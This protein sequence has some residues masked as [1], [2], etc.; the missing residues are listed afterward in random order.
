MA[1]YV[2]QIECTVPASST[3]EV[4]ADSEQEAIAQTEADIAKNGWHS[5]AWQNC[6]PWT[7]VWAAAEH[8]TTTGEAEEV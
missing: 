4:E 3:V 5:R 1:S 2:V 8:L 7:C 6:A